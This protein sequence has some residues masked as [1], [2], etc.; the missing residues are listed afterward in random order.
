MVKIQFTAKFWETYKE[1]LQEGCITKEQV[2]RS[3]DL[4][5]INP[6]DTR[7]FNHALKKQLAGQYAFS[8]NNDIRIVYRWLGK[9][10]AQF[11]KIGGHPR[12][13]S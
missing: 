2:K 9:N 6:D 11:L 5:R 10:L 8:V 1:I 13:Y 3:T 12:V 7:I 4:F